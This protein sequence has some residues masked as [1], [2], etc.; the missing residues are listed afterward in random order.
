MGEEKALQEILLAAKRVEVAIFV[1]GILEGEGRN[2]AN[3][4]LPGSQEKIIKSLARAGVPAELLFPVMQGKRLFTII[5]N[6]QVEVGI[7][8]I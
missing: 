6:R 2:R 5:R 4:A 3:L 1:A 8:L 7:T